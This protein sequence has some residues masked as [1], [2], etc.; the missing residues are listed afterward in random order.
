MHHLLVIVHMLGLLSR[1]YVPA[2]S[3]KFCE[4]LTLKQKYSE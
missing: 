2:T 3:F 4:N 1:I